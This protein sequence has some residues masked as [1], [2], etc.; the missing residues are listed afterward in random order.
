MVQLCRDHLMKYVK[1]FFVCVLG[2][3]EDEIK[4]LVWGN[5][6]EIR[7]LKIS[8][9]IDKSCPFINCSGIQMD[10][11]LWFGSKKP[12]SVCILFILHL[13]LNYLQEVKQ[14]HKKTKNKTDTIWF[15][16]NISILNCSISTIKQAYDLLFQII[17]KCQRIW[18]IICNVIFQIVR[19]LFIS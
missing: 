12:Q 11:V 18:A 14:P 9:C 1:G 13:K 8:K 10:P 5:S 15:P 19:W 7:I 6:L 4:I 2:R 3:Q 16:I 17:L